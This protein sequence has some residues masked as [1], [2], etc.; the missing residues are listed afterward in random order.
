MIQTLLRSLLVQ[1]HS[2]NTSGERPADVVIE[3]DLT[4]FDLAEFE[5]TPELAAVG[6]SATLEQ[7]PK[8]RLLLNRL[9]PKLFS[10]SK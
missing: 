7:V 6:E 8:I 4:A 5:R 1:H 10:Q 2:L 3:P 9:D